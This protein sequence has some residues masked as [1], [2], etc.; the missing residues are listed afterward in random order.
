MMNK[1]ANPHRFSCYKGTQQDVVLYKE[2]QENPVLIGD[3]NK[4]GSVTIAD[5]TALVNIL[6]NKDTTAYDLNA[7]D[8]DRANGI[9]VADVE[10]L[11]N[12]I[13]EKTN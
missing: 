12:I 9:T 2:L 3:V 13:L 6:L 11:V 8:V 4:D 10:E 7:A 1:G 5:V